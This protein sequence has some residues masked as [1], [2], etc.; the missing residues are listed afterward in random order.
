MGA[1][2][3][4]SHGVAQGTVAGFIDEEEGQILL[5][6]SPMESGSVGSLEDC[7]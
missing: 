2:S 6:I 3:Q 5:S 1:G 4:R 7:D